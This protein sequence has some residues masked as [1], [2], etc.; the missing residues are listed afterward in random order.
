MKLA[1]VRIITKDVQALSRFY[2]EITGVT[3]FGVEDYQEFQTPGG[4]FAISSQK[5]MDLHGAGA[6]FAAAN[7]SVI[8]DFE[9]ADVDQ[10]RERLSAIVEE[11]VLEPT[12]QPWGTRSMMFRDR[13]GNLVNFFARVS[14]HEPITNKLEASL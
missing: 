5:K 12:N 8:L 14:V 10:E 9:V 4:S 3:P 11:F 1:H 6:A 2:E 7:R 13:D